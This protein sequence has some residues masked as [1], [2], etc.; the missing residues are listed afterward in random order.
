MACADVATVKAKAIAINL[1]I[2]LSPCVAV[3]VVCHSRSRAIDYGQ[4]QKLHATSPSSPENSS[5]LLIGGRAG[6]LQGRE[7]CEVFVNKDR[8]WDKSLQIDTGHLLSK[9]VPPSRAVTRLG[10]ACTHIHSYD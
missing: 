2:F 6:D 1:I 3:G 4:A 9:V 5:W 10:N 8:L 7:R